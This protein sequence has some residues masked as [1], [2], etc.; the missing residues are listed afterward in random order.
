MVF[1]DFDQAERRLERLKKEKG[2]VDFERGALVKCI[3]WLE[4]GKPLRTL[5]MTAQ[6]L[7]AFASFGFLSRKPALAVIN[8]DADRAT[9]ELPASEQAA[10]TRS[11]LRSLSP[12]CRV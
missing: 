7:Q 12:G 6:E 10:I 11:W 3:A 4:Q 2:P 1:A 5:E 9:A 8:C